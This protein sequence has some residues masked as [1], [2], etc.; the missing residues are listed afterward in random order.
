MVQP[1]QKD[2]DP[3]KQAQNGTKEAHD[4]EIEHRVVDPGKTVDRSD[5]PDPVMERGKFRG[6]ARAAGVPDGDYHD[7]LAVSHRLDRH[8][9]LDLK[10][11][12]F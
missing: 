11:G 12:L 5:D 8:L 6:R 9:G 3:G 1:F 7:P 2:I 10:T 4:P